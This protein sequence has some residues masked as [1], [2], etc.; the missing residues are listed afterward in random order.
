MITSDLKYVETA[1]FGQLGRILVKNKTITGLVVNYHL[2]T[3]LPLIGKQ[4]KIL[5]VSYD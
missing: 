3:S 5:K 4:R 2:Y 1:P